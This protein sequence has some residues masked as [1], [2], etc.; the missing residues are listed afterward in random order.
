MH[1]QYFVGVCIGQH[2][3]HAG[4]IAQSTGPAVGQKRESAG[5][6]SH[7]IGLELLFGTPDPGDFGTGVNDPG[8]QIEV[9][10]TVLT[11]DA[12][13]NGHALFFGFVGQHG[14]AHHV[15]YCPHA[16]HIGFAI[17]IDG[18]RAPVV[19]LQAN[20]FGVQA[21]GVGHSTNGHDQFVHIQCL[22]FALGVGV[23]DADAFFA[24]LD[25]ADFDAELDIQTLL[26]KNLFG[27]FGDLL[28]HRAEK[29]RQ[30]FK[31]GDLSAQTPPDRTHFQTDHTR[32]YEREFFRYSAQSQGTVVGKNIFFI[33][34]ST[35]QCTR[36]G[37]GSNNDLLSNQ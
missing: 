25:V 32:A 17:A 29:C 1:A 9:D 21:F 6:V 14:A 3:H 27:F 20:R 23:I 36:T 16:G 31:N 24:V 15:T 35:R 37:T 11:G 33:K 4:G 12:F 22:G 2:F 13:S 5:F 34:S 10:M 26:V 8:H 7:A 28:I 18:N 30:S 19:E